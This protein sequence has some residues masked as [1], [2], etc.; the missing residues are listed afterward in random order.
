MILHPGAA[1]A[2]RVLDCDELGIA[3]LMAAGELASPQR[4]MNVML[5]NLR[6]TGTGVSYRPA[7][8]EY[9]Y[10]K[11]EN[12]LTQ[13]FLDRC[14]GL[15]VI[16]KHPPK[17]LLNHEEFVE[18]IAGTVFLPYIRDD[19]VWC[20]SKLYDADAIEWM[21]DEQIS[22]SPAVLLGN[23]S[24]KL[25]GENGEKILEEGKPKLLDHLAIVSRGVWDKGGEATGVEA[26]IRGDSAMSKEE[27][28][29]ARK[30][31]EETKAR[32]DKARKD[33]EEKERMDGEKLDQMLKGIDGLRSDLADCNKRMDAWDEEKK[34]ADAL[35]KDGEGGTEAERLAA[36]KAKKDAEDAEKEKAKADKAK[37]DAEEE[38]K[39]KA[40]AARADSV[41]TLKDQLKKQ[42]EQIKAL[43]AKIPASVTDAD[44]HALVARQSRADD[45]FTAFGE[46]APRPQV[47]ETEG[48]YRRR[49]A[50]LLQKHSDQW[51]EVVL[52]AMP[53]IAFDKIESQV[54]ADAATRARMP[55]DLAKNAIRER[56]RDLG[57]GHKVTEFF[58]GEGAHFV[59]GFSRNVRRVRGIR[60]AN[61]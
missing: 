1:A 50:G 6:V 20:I 31:A 60:M 56:T 41:E 59:R 23:D 58:G 4:Y 43:A 29:K 3:R 52:D 8:K 2:L 15:P 17:S 19:E 21:N 7:L 13:E 11:P 57:T 26:D 37:A 54:Y 32:E 61:G 25:V 51:K 14:N 22:T 45:I 36:D 55:N 34:K 46:R 49:I 28:D 38:E 5:Y 33:A 10:R 35:R 30:D 24:R 12:Y 44:Y 9:V 39:K 16:V 40:D 18:R 53:D 27:E 42:D 47:G 48:M